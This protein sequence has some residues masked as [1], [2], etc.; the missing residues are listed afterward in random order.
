MKNFFDL[1]LAI[2]G[3]FLIIGKLVLAVVSL[4]NYLDGNYNVAT[5]QMLVVILLEL[6]L[7]YL[8]GG[9]E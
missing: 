4:L 6:S 7:K 3:L 2:L 1:V 5:Y 8:K 9:E